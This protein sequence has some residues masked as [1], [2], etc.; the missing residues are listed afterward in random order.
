MASLEGDTTA[1]M[2]YNLKK[3][4]DDCDKRKGST[5]DCPHDNEALLE[6]INTFV[7][8][9]KSLQTKQTGCDSGSIASHNLSGPCDL[10][11]AIEWVGGGLIGWCVGWQA[12]NLGGLMAGPKV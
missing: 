5:E 6:E 3:A 12:H 11:L 9:G 8:R 4:V 2:R 1:S 7:K 10:R